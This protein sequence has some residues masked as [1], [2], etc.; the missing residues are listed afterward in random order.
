[1]GIGFR[2]TL[3]NSQ[4]TDLADGRVFLSY[5]EQVSL[6]RGAARGIRAR[7]AGEESAP[8]IYIRAA[9]TQ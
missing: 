3:L 7:L 9:V 4:K 6:V 1:M 2:I 5:S 8:P